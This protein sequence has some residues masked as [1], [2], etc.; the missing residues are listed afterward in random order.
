MPVKVNYLLNLPDSN[1][2]LH[3]LTTANEPI[4]G[5]FAVAENANNLI[6]DDSQQLNEWQKKELDQM[7]LQH[8]TKSIVSKEN[9]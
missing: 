4:G 6:K 7:I 5:D 9:I 3:N 2:Y 1:E 8:I